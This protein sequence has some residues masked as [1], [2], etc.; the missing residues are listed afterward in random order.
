MRWKEWCRLWP[1]M[2]AAQLG[3][4]WP[5]DSYCPRCDVYGHVEGSAYCNLLDEEEA[6]KSREG[7]PLDE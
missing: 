1:R 5:D 7:L 2:T 4:A 3:T 6:R